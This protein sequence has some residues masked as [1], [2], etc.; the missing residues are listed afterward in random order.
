[1]GKCN[2]GKKK[3]KSYMRGEKMQRQVYHDKTIAG[4][5]QCDCPHTPPGVT[6]SSFIYSCLQ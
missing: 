6:P 5:S 4:K 1:M 3:D 2:M